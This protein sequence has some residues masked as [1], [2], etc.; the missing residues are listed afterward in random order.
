MR[1]VVR[2]KPPG[3]LSNPTNRLDG[4]RIDAHLSLDR[5]APEI[6]DSAHDRLPRWLFFLRTN[7]DGRL[8]PEN[9]ADMERLSCRWSHRIWYMC[10][11]GFGM[12]SS[13]PRDSHRSRMSTER[14]RTLD[15]ERMC[16]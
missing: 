7:L 4:H 13:L 6:L 2:I 3:S 5:R 12:P 14:G 11:A 1:L 8:A 10:P 9:R 15:R 16:P